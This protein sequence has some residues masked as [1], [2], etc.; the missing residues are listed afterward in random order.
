M[1]PLQ[2]GDVRSNEELTHA[3]GAGLRWITHARIAIEVVTLGS[4]LVLA[5]LITP[6]EFGVFAVVVI[7]QELALTMP[8]EGIGS[9][10]VQRRTIVREH[11][12]GGMMLSLLVGVALV[13]VTL[14][15]ADVLVD[16]LFGHRPARL[17]R[18]AT[19]WYLLGA[20]YAVPVA[21]LRRRLDFARLSLIDIGLSVSRAVVTVVLAIAGFDAEALI[22]GCMAGM[23][24]A[25]VM[26]A[27]FAPPPLPRWRPRAM[28]DLL[29]YGGPA[30]LA[31]VAWTGFRNG[32][33]LIIGA[34]LGTAQAGFYWR[35]Y[36][37]S[38][39]Y[40]R[41]ISVLMSQM[42]F[43]VL[44]RTADSDQMHA[45]RRRMVQ[46]LTVVLFPMLL[47]LALLAPVLVPWAFGAQWEPAVLPTQILTLGG[48][49][50]LVTDA[51]GSALMA[52]GRSRALLGYGVAHFAVYAGAVVIVASR[53]LAAVAIAAAVVHTVFL[54]IAYRVL[55]RG[56]VA[57]A[58]RELWADLAPALVA[59]VALIA[60]AGPG[61]W[62]LR[63]LEAPAPIHL[64]CIG[65]V[66]GVAYLAA[67]RAW[68]PATFGDLRA[69]LRRIV[70]ARVMAAGA[71][72]LSALRPAGRRV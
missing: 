63:L 65:A 66:G 47:M 58:A 41:R 36:Q 10:L 28:R 64:A 51:A 68:F 9:A 25:V 22:L 19:P 69:A 37:L 33:Y 70:P 7:V 49:A 35:G 17:V 55:L 23:L 21:K 38:V 15:L 16:P 13:A 56:T 42:A 26:A 48:A 29:S 50:V 44:A 61:E 52:S 60:V 32:D 72:R 8:M 2:P 34:R 71:G 53:G 45:L 24:T 1:E 20:I 5:R 59:C 46:L 14:L 57:S 54:L 6:A 4:M 31:C 62:A 40:Q 11:Y 43:P 18:L 30:A 67:L 3:A 12:E 27:W 39:E